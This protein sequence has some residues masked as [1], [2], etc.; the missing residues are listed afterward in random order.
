MAV[1]TLQHLWTTGHRIVNSHMPPLACMFTESEGPN[2]RKGR[3][4]GMP[5]S[6]S[7]CA[8]RVWVNIAMRDDRYRYLKTVRGNRAEMMY[9]TICVA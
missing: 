1:T 5:T 6:T 9:V 8:M 4:Y 3:Q 2:L 7:Q